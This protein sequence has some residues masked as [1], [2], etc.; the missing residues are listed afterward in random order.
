MQAGSQ[1][2]AGSLNDGPR[3]AS[4]QSLV[5]DFGVSGLS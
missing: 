5:E 2:V 4:D 3:G 1:I